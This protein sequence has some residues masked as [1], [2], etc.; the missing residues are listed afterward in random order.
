MP[1][2]TSD[3]LRAARQ[4]QDGELQITPH[5]FLDRL[6]RDHPDATDVDRDEL[7]TALEDAGLIKASEPTHPSSW[8]GNTWVLNDAGFAA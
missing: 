8:N 2:S 6:H 4:A 5:G 7:L 3:A 1:I